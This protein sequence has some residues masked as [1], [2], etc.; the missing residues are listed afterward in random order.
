MWVLGYYDGVTWQSW[1]KYIAD[2]G[3]RGEGINDPNFKIVA[4]NPHDP[5]K[6]PHEYSLANDKLREKLC[7]DGIVWACVKVPDNRL[8]EIKTLLEQSDAS[9]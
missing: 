9:V 8:D 3:G 4:E 1:G 5:F 7:P 6:K 2:K